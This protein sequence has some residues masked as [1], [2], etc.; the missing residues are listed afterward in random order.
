VKRV[1][2]SCIGPVNIRLHAI[3]YVTDTWN[4]VISMPGITQPI[5]SR[6]ISRMPT[7]DST[8]GPELITPA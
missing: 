4:C 2:D 8:H 5:D 3:R 6:P 1:N 7:I